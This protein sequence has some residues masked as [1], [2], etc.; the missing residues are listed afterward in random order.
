MSIS[1]DDGRSSSLKLTGVGK[2]T[3]KTLAPIIS[4]HREEALLGVSDAEIEQLNN[5]LKKLISNCS[6]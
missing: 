1:K 4:A 6:D 5:T 3:L 2:S